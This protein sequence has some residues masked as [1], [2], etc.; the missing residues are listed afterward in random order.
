MPSASTSRGLRARTALLGAVLVTLAATM[1]VPTPA[2]AHVRGL[3]GGD[4]PLDPFAAATLEERREAELAQLP[5]ET[6]RG[7]CLQTDEVAGLGVAC[8]TIDG[9][10]RV[11][12]AVGATVTTHGTDAPAAI[13]E[14]TAAAPH[15]P[16]TQ[17]ALD[18]ASVDD[19]QCVSAPGDRRIELVYTYPANRADRYASLV[20]PMRQAIYQASAFVDAESQAL[21]ADEGRRLRVLCGVDGLPTVHRVPLP[22]SSGA[23][24]DYGDIVD[25]LVAR[26]YPAPTWG[27]TSTRRFMIFHDED[28]ADGSAGVGGIW[29]D[30]S[31]GVGN[32]NNLGARYAIEFNWSAS[33]LPHWDLFLHEI[34]HNM[35]AVANGAPDASG[36]LHCIDGL[37]VM[38]YDDG[39]TSGT[40]TTTTCTLRRFD[41]GG[42][43]YFNPS[44]A[45]GTWLANQ[46]NVASTDNLWLDARDTGWDDGGV[47]DTI[48]PPTPSGL[49]STSPTSSSFTA[50]WDA[51]VDDRSTVRYRV[52][53]DRLV[54]G[55]WQA[56]ASPTSTS[57]T[58]L[59]TVGLPSGTTWRVRVAA[60]DRAGNH[61]A[62]AMLQ[63][64]TT[65]AAPVAPSTIGA[66]PTSPTTLDI[67]WAAGIADGGVRGY[68]LELQAGGGTWQTLG[69]RGTLTAQATGLGAGVTYRARVRTAS[70][71]GAVSSWRLSAPVTMP[72]TL[73]GTS[74]AAAPVVTISS[75]GAARFRAMWSTDGV[76]ASWTVELHDASGQLL[77]LPVA[78]PTAMLTGL[79]PR[80]TYLLVVLALDDDGRELARSASMVET[81]ADTTAPARTTLLRAPQ[82]IGST[83]RIAWRAAADDV[84][85]ARYEL[86]RARGRRWVRIPLGARATTASVARL[87]ARSTTVLRLR[88][89][90]A[91]GNR[92]A[93]TMIRIRRR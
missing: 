69:E 16:D 44:P 10:F 70:M 84:G 60:F 43:S 25:A 11:Q 1:L 56:Y 7:T 68:Q 72:G 50:S 59:P 79:Q 55:S 71:S 9:L 61:S 45:P 65:F 57:L 12:L 58:S 39:G 91:T 29:F 76:A 30:D 2:S 52:G 49:R 46:W 20:G 90:D 73:R 74:E 14:R 19:I 54:S 83:A 33:H 22:A 35:G 93:W 78:A 28:S 8:R 27:T 89:V 37:D 13:V 87:R 41:C 47:P 92:G 80:T 42:D 88:A 86:Q 75:L 82:V 51:S 40:Y 21:D 63:L 81:L 36:A 4:E 32:A 6:A 67:A 66:T 23:G 17:T 24:G 34:S 53:I 38:C 26:G 77:E 48:A 5:L 62:D 15:L 3:G 18:T 85:V 31:A 64:A